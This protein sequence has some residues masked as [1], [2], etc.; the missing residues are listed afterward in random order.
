MDY[1]F[2][3]I[4]LF[5]AMDVVFFILGIDIEKYAFKI[6]FFVMSMILSFSLMGLMI[7]TATEYGMIYMFFFFFL[8]FINF[9]LIIFYSMNAYDETKTRQWEI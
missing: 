8:G 5:F 6:L 4:V 7:A 2:V 1:L 3:G 9:I